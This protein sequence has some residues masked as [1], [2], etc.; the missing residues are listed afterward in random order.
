MDTECLQFVLM[1]LKQSH[2]RSIQIFNVFNLLLSLYL[3]SKLQYE[4]AIILGKERLFL[5]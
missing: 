3:Y 4:T 5:G 2:I 1:S